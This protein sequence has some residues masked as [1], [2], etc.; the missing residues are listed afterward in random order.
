VIKENQ[1]ELSDIKKQLDQVTKLV[2][3]LM[4]DRVN[5][6]KIIRTLKSKIHTMDLKVQH[7]ENTLS[8]MKK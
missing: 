1:N 6:Q 7:I 5:N 3:S 8:R 2:K 4:Q